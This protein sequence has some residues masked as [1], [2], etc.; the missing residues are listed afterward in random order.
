MIE[1]AKDKNISLSYRDGKK[2]KEIYIKDGNI[3]IEEKTEV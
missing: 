1:M 2:L 3:I